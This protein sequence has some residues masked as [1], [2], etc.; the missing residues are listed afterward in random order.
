M[1]ALCRPRAERIARTRRREQPRGL[2]VGQLPGHGMSV[3]ALPSSYRLAGSPVE[4]P[5]ALAG[6]EA[7]EHERAFD[8]PTQAKFGNRLRVVFHPLASQSLRPG[9]LAG[10]HALSQVRQELLRVLLSLPRLAFIEGVAHE[11]QDAKVHVPLDMVC[12]RALAVHVRHSDQ[13]DGLRVPVLRRAP[14]GLHPTAHRLAGVR[15]IRRTVQAPG[16]R[17]G[18]LRTRRNWSGGQPEQA[19]RAQ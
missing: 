2:L 8:S 9:N 5:V 1:K 14:A 11:I 17:T 18:V 10:G 3:R 6:A 4:F 16:Q 12:L 7:L 15:L 19:K 13:H